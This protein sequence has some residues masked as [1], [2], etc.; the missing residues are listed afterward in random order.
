VA[1]ALTHD[2]LI[3]AHQQLGNDGWLSAA[4]ASLVQG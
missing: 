4:L 1:P 3:D 2:D